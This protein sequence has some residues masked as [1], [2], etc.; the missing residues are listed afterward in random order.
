MCLCACVRACVRVCVCVCV[1][2]CMCVCVCVFVCGC[3]RMRAC[4]HAYVCVCVCACHL[5]LGHIAPS[6]ERDKENSL[7][8][9]SRSTKHREG[10]RELTCHWVE[11]HQSQRGFHWGIGGGCQACHAPG[12]TRSRSPARTPAC[13]GCSQRCRSRSL[14]EQRGSMSMKPRHLECFK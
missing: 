14:C 8:I 12:E 10:Q 1:C 6:T 2:V 4:V 13:R 3:A 5:S 7:V 9:G 11:E